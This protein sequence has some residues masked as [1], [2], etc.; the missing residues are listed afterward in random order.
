MP[1][2]FAEV[3]SIGN[4]IISGQIL[5]TNSQWLS[6][7]LE[8]LGFR[9]LHHT[10]V[11]DE[12]DAMVEAFRQAIA[13]SD[14]VVS[15]GGL[16]PTLADLTREALARATGRKLVFSAGPRAHPPVVRSPQAAHARRQRSPSILS[17]GE[18]GSRESQRYR[19]G[20]Q[21]RGA[22]PRPR[23]CRWIALPGVPAEVKEMWNDSVADTLGRSRARERVIR[24]RRIKCFGAGESLIAAHLPDLIQKGDN[25]RVGITAS[26]TVITLRLAASGP[27][28][29]AALA[30]MEPAVATIRARLGTLVFGEDDDELQDAIVR[31]LSQAHATLSVVEWGTH[32]QI[33]D[34]LG[35]V[36]KSD[37]CVP[38]GLVIRSHAALRR[39]LDVAPPGEHS[40]PDDQWV[41]RLAEACRN[42]FATTYALAVGPLPDPDP[43]AVEAKPVHFALAGPAATQARSIPSAS[44]P[45]LAKTY[46]ANCAGPAPFAPRP[47]GTYPRTAAGTLCGREITAS[48]EVLGPALRTPGCHG[49]GRTPLPA[50]ERG[51]NANFAL[52]PDRAFQAPR[53]KL[54]VHGHQHMG[55]ELPVAMN[56]RRDPRIDRLQGADHFGHGCHRHLGVSHSARQFLKQKRNRHLRHQPAR[57]QSFV[58]GWAGV[59]RS[60]RLRRA[61]RLLLLLRFHGTLEHLELPRDLPGMWIELRRLALALDRTGVVA[62]GVVHACQRVV[63][64]AV[65]G[66]QFQRLLRA[67]QGFLQIAFGVRQQPCQV[68]IGPR[69]VRLLAHF[70]AHF[71]RGGLDRLGHLHTQRGS[72]GALNCRAA[73]N[74]STFEASAVSAFS[75]ASR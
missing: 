38:G 16:G 31:A 13:R 37:A 58:T 51:Q 22:P 61:G 20:H 64:T 25:P 70:L 74:T 54:P 12:L 23:P 43:K 30:I 45:A 19:P 32:G 53:R 36:A 11:G 67:P 33:L 1:T 39:L 42:H 63:E 34:R 73:I 18:P 15:T 6:L 55:I 65:I 60:R 69:P 46:C 44:H 27:T 17:R 28:E 14:L 75:R 57:F 21:S 68:V 24:H 72:T 49:K 66:L 26:S 2:H 62:A 9:V 48:P 29:A 10:V 3:L 41:C 50:A 59:V 47:I 8:E 5:D 71:R 35:S 40:E 56:P 52:R 7:R 4:E